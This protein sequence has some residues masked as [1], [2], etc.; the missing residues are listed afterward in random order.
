MTVKLTAL[1]LEFLAE[2]LRAV[3]EG[4]FEYDAC[5]DEINWARGEKSK[6]ALLGSLSKKGLVYLDNHPDPDD[7][8]FPQFGFGDLDEVRALVS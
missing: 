6:A 4:C 8:A 2:L 7:D 1:E 5:C 3:E